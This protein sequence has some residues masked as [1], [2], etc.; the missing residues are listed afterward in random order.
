MIM[1]EEPLECVKFTA[2][3]NPCADGYQVPSGSSHASA[4]GIG[5]YEWLDF[6][7]GS[8]SLY[9]EY[10]EYEAF[11]DLILANS[12]GRKP[13]SYNGCFSIRP[14][15]GIMN[16]EGVVGQF[17]WVPPKLYSEANTDFAASISG[18]STCPLFFGRDISRFSEF[19]SVWYGSSPMLKITITE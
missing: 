12:S 15:A 3:F 5:S 4:A 11:T 18:S 13:A 16:T 7:L 8:D 9:P 14:S 10:A 1:R 17:P 19:I 2:P 6:S